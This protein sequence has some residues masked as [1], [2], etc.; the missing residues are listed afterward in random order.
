MKLFYRQMINLS[1]C[2]ITLYL[3]VIFI[4]QVGTYLLYSML[5]ITI[6][7][8]LPIIILLY[9]LLFVTIGGSNMV[10]KEELPLCPVEI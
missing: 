9:R 2:N 1:E 6:D 3:E 7:I 8:L 5:F 4:S 10:S